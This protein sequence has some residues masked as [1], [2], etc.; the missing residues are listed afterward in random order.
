MDCYKDTEQ[1]VERVASIW[2]WQLFQRRRRAH[3]VT[4]GESLI[5]VLIPSVII[6]PS[7]D[8]SP[9]R[10]LPAG[11]STRFQ[12]PSSFILQRGSNPLSVQFRRNYTFISFLCVS[13]L[14]WT[15]FVPER[16]QNGFNPIIL[17]DCDYIPIAFTGRSPSQVSNISD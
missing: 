3:E 9:T 2:N 16:D 14:L 15:C 13:Y 7:F 17:H 11:N 8:K 12:S 5:P 4:R 10:F 1:E 6:L